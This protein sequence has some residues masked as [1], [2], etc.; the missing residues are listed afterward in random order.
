MWASKSCVFFAM[1]ASKIARTY[2]KEKLTLSLL[3]FTMNQ[4]LNAFKNKGLSLKY[5]KVMRIKY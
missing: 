1:R 3:T 5:F 2:C 4:L